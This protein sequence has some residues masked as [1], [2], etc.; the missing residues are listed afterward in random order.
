MMARSK[1]SLFFNYMQAQRYI[2]NRFSKLS[3]PEL[4][5]AT[6]FCVTSASFREGRRI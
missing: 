3:I 6:R 1:G 4:A 5:S 2:G